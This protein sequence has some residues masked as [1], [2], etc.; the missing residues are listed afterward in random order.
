MAQDMLGEYFTR[1]RQFRWQE[2]VMGG[3]LLLLLLAMKHCG[4]S[5]A[6]CRWMRPAGPITAC[7]ISIICVYAGV[8]KH[9]IRIVSHIPRGMP[10]VTVG[11][12]LPISNFGVS[13]GGPAASGGAAAARFVFFFV[14]GGEAGCE[15]WQVYC[16]LY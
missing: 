12:W 14:F 11:W 3:S 6:R 15:N 10:S 13:D 4:K 8:D 7:V 2:F 1:I 16:F 9:G 5:Y